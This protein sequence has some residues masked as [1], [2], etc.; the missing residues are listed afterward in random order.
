MSLKCFFHLCKCRA[1]QG[2]PWF[3]KQCDAGSSPSTKKIDMKIRIAITFSSFLLNSAVPYLI[4][5]ALPRGRVITSWV[6]VDWCLSPFNTIALSITSGFHL[7]FSTV[8]ISITAGG[9]R[10]SRYRYI[11]ISRFFPF[12]LKCILYIWIEMQ[13]LVY[14][15]KWILNWQLRLSFSRSFNTP[16]NIIKRAKLPTIHVFGFAKSLNVLLL[17]MFIRAR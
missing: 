11:L 1:Q 8:R 15:F 3:W 17:L 10:I 16:Y 14:M 2:S 13:I 9:G 6:L 5:V 7:I 12:K 4:T